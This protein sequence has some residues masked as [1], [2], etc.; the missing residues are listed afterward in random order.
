MARAGEQYVF[1]IEEAIKVL[2]NLKMTSSA[3]TQ[4]IN[5]AASKSL[6]PVKK[7]AKTNLRAIGNKSKTSN[8]GGFSK[9]QYIARSISVKPLVKGAGARVKAHGADIPVGN[10]LWNV[11]GYAKLLSAGSY[12]TKQRKGSGNF[13]GFG[14]Y[15]KDAGD[16][17]RQE[18]QRLFIQ[19]MIPQMNRVVAKTIRRWG[20][21][22][23]S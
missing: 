10:K 16:T 15:V 20:R 3:D 21:K 18:V 2:D 14:N 11:E 1:G 5:G 12:K 13:K 9:L 23:G 7:Q 17:K 8:N 22:Y 4:V 6:S 19:N